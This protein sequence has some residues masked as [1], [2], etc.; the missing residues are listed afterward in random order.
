[1]PVD[2]RNELA[3][4]AIESEEDEF[5]RALISKALDADKN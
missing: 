4:N 3:E 2:E 1:L 5:R